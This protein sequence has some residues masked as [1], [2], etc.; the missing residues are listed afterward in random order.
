MANRQYVGARY[1]PK[2]ANPVEWDNVRQYEALTIVTHLGNSFTSKKPVPAGVDIGNTEYWVNTGNYNE[3]IAA[4]RDVV[5]EYKAEVEAVKGLTGEY[6]N[7]TKFGV[8]PGKYVFNPH[9]MLWR[10]S[11]GTVPTDVSNAIKTA[12][13]FCE[14]NGI[15]AI[16][17]PN[18]QYYCGSNNFSVNVSKIKLLGSTNTYLISENC[19]SASFITLTADEN[20]TQYANPQEIIKNIKVFGNYFENAKSPTKNIIGINFNNNS[21]FNNSVVQNIGCYGFNV[22]MS[23]NNGSYKFGIYNYTAY[24][25]DKAISIGNYYSS[26]IP[27][28]FYNPVISVCNTAFY[29]E[30]DNYVIVTGGSI[31]YNRFNLIGEG[32]FTF[33]NVRF[34]FDPKSCIND[35]GTIEYPFI[36][37]HKVANPTIA[38]SNCGFFCL[39]AYAHNV[40]YWTTKKDTSNTP[41]NAIFYS[42]DPSTYVATVLFSNCNLKIDENVFPTS[43][44]LIETNNT[45]IDAKGLKYPLIDV[46]PATKLNVLSSDITKIDPQFSGITA[47]AIGDE[48]GFVCGSNAYV[49]FKASPGSVVRFGAVFDG[50][51]SVTITGN[52]GEAAS[53]NIFN[54]PIKGGWQVFA[55]YVPTGC[56]EIK[57]NF[58][59]GVK[60][61][62]NTQLGYVQ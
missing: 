11:D 57:F 32:T 31:E 35:A 51:G 12:I 60:W 5:L 26:A 22:G 25:C 46:M 24:I 62:R 8:S 55:A 53:V 42:S 3:Q 40:D 33:N 58:P 1:V 23:I 9:T 41:A 61:P 43:H 29:N 47:T 4:Y 45:N 44:C 16:Y 34:E 59:S 30:G 17:F 14:E 39:P 15:S 6:V 37:T 13:S 48:Y 2:F 36:F 52:K 27:V 19:N 56:D 20:S 38:F 18:G 7:I 21:Y 49:S 50:T 54:T 28:Q 10:N